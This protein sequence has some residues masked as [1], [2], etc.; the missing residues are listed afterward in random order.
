[1]KKGVYID[2][3]EKEEVVIYRETVFLPRWKELERHMVIFHED[4]SWE[5]PSGMLCDS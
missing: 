3:H 4:G 2:G 5:L 1:V